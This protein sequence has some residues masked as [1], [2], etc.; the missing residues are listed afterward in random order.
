MIVQCRDIVFSVSGFCNARCIND[1]EVD[2]ATPTIEDWAE[3]TLS[4]EM[5]T[6]MQPTTEIHKHYHIESNKLAFLGE[7]NNG[8]PPLFTADSSHHRRE[9]FATL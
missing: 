3:D 9:V 8:T 5:M 7:S 1:L 2:I 6:M 4:D